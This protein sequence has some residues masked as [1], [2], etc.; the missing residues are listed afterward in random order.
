[1]AQHNQLS[2]QGFPLRP[3]FGVNKTMEGGQ[4]LCTWRN[5][6]A[7]LPDHWLRVIVAD[8]FRKLLIN[9][10]PGRPAAEFVAGAA[11]LMV[12]IVGEGMTEELD[13]TRVQQGF[14]QLFRTLNKWP[15][16]ADVLKA[17]PDRR[18]SPP[19]P[20]AQTAEEADID[21]TASGEKLQD[22]LDMLE[23]GGRD[24]RST[25]TE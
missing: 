5:A 8:V 13:S 15:Q 16:P 11:E 18:P 7:D 19:S 23:N 3:I 10:T 4:N 24:G 20:R 2:V 22:I 14:K 6:G 21:T 1:M 9:N 25:E 12:E 17:L